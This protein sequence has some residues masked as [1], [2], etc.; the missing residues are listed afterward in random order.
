MSE[1]RYR[2]IVKNCAS[3]SQTLTKEVSEKVVDEG[4]EYGKKVLATMRKVDI[5]D[6]DPTSKAALA[7]ALMVSAVLRPR[8]GVEPQ[9]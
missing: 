6:L 5:D 3:R 1:K 9:G 2:D 7:Q 8:G 4:R